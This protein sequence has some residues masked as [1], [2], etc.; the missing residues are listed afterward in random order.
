MIDDT[1]LVRSRC[2]VNATIQG[3][4][5]LVTYPQQVQA[6]FPLHGVFPVR[7]AG[8]YFTSAEPLHFR[9]APINPPAAGPARDR[10]PDRGVAVE[11]SRAVRRM[12]RRA[13][14]VAGGQG[15]DRRHRSQAA[16]GRHTGRVRRA[17]WRCCFRS[18]CSACGCWRTSSGSPPE[19]FWCWPSSS[20]SPSPPSCSR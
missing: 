15:L 11:P 3:Q 9:R 7:S 2:R 13:H 1:G 18:S 10:L 17:R 14:S 5:F 20:A 19:S 12:G 4:A 6:L 16:A 8:P